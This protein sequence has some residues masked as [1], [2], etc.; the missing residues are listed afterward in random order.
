MI[1]H[2]NI[3]RNHIFH[4]H[5][6]VCAFAGETSFG[7]FKAF[8]WNLWNPV[9]CTCLLPFLAF[10]CFFKKNKSLAIII[11]TLVLS[12]RFNN[13]TLPLCT[14]LG[15]SFHTIKTNFSRLH[16]LVHHD[17]GYILT[18]G[19]NYERQCDKLISL[20]RIMT[21]NF[22]EMIC[23]KIITFT[24]LWQRATMKCIVTKLSLFTEWEITDECL[25]LLVVFL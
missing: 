14:N 12:F 17:K 19:Y 10:Q 20:Y 7:G 5:I 16:R 25:H 6:E 21:E 11:I 13:R 3:N 15:H 23:D 1:I 2:I 9:K 4:F 18:K 8:V 22:N 24:Q